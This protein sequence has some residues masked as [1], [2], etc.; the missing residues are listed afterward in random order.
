MTGRSHR[1]S[2]APLYL[3][4]T[5]GYAQLLRGRR[6]TSIK[7]AE[8]TQS[9]HQPPRVKQA[10]AAVRNCYFSGGRVWNF[11]FSMSCLRPCRMLLF[12]STP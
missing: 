2:E 9:D 5:R 6:V 4:R 8:V 7:F 3:T 1:A 10:K 11:R 12:L